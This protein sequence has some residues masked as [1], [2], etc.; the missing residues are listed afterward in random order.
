MALGSIAR[1]FRNQEPSSANDSHL[2]AID[3]MMD[4][5]ERAGNRVAFYFITD[6]NHPL[7]AH[8]RMD[9]P[10]IRRLLRRIHDHGHEIGLHPSYTSYS[11][12]K[13]TVKE[14]NILRSAMEAEGIHQTEIGGRQHFLRWSSPLTAR[15]WEAAGMQYDSTLSYADQAGFRCGT[16]HEFQMFDPTQ[17]RALKLRQRPLV[18]ME[19]SVIAD[20]YMGLGYSDEALAVMQGFKSVCKRVG[21]VF[22]LLWHNSHFSGERDK[23][24]YGEMVG[25]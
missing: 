18:L 16:C 8:Y 9:E 17:D 14:A 3:W 21:G 12:S 24:F 4:V 19:C 23:E 2:A 15:N 11:D 25:Q 10:V 7:D 22:T 13:R 20:R 6:R 5:N 1:G